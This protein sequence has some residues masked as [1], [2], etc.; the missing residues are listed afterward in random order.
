MPEQPSTARGE[1]TR[2]RILAAATEEFAARG[3][4]GARM[5]RITTA[6]RTNKAQVYS[7]VD[8]NRVGDHICY[9]SDLSKMRKHFPS[10]DITQSLAETIRQIV[11]AWQ[12]RPQV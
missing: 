6:A 4:A 1:A 2:L 3:I 10:W 8:R 11:E 9:Y 5:E 7:Y 12:H